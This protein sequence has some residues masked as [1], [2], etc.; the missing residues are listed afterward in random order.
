MQ[1]FADAIVCFPKHD[2]ELTRA[3]SLKQDMRCPTKRAPRAT[4][5]HELT[6][7]SWTWIGERA[8]AADNLRSSAEL[9]FSP[10]IALKYFSM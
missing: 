7:H 10:K 9:T 5:I 8:P 6:G 4:I 2:I 1:A 3:A